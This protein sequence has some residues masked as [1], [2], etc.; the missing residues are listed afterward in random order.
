[1][2]FWDDV[3]RFAGNLTGGFLGESDEERKK[4]AREAAAAKAA[5]KGTLDVKSAVDN[6]GTLSVGSDNTSNDELKMGKVKPQEVTVE[7]PRLQ[8]DEYTRWNVEQFD[9]MD[10]DKQRKTIETAEADL[11]RYKSGNTIEDAHMQYK[12]GKNLDALKTYGKKKDGN[13]LTFGGDIL[14]G[15]GE[16]LRVTGEGLGEG[17]AAATGEN[18]K[19]AEAQNSYADLLTDTAIKQKKAGKISQEQY[20]NDIAMADQERFLA[21]RMIDRDIEAADPIKMA[22]HVASAIATPISYAAGVGSAGQAGMAG[23]GILSSKAAGTVLPSILRSNATQLVARAFPSMGPKMLSTTGAILE[24]ILFNAPQAAT[25]VAEAKGGDATLADYAGAQLQSAVSS[26]ALP[27]FASVAGTIISKGA[28]GITNQT[29]SRAVQAVIRQ[30]ETKLGRK[31]DDAELNVIKG[32]TE[33]IVAQARKRFQQG[34]IEAGMFDPTGKLGKP[35]PLEQEAIRFNSPREFAKSLYDRVQNF[36]KTMKLTNAQKDELHQFV[37]FKMQDRANKPPQWVSDAFDNAQ[38]KN[39]ARIQAQV[40]APQVTKTVAKFKNADEVANAFKKETGSDIRRAEVELGGWEMRRNQGQSEPIPYTPEQIK[41]IDKYNAIKNP[42]SQYLFHTTPTSNLDSIRKNGLTTGNKPRFEGVSNPKEISLSANELAAEYYGSGND[43][44]IRVSKKYGKTIPDLKG[45]YLAGG[46]GVYK[47]SQ[48]IPASALEVKI[49]GKWQ[50][51]ESTPQVTKTDITTTKPITTDGVV[52]NPR[53]TGLSPESQKLVDEAD[54]AFKQN[55]L[56]NAKVLQGQVDELNKQLMDLKTVGSQEILDAKLNRQPI[57]ESSADQA[58]AIIRTILEKKREIARLSG[59]DFNSQNIKQLSP[60]E[61]QILKQGIQSGE[62]KPLDVPVPQKIIDLPDKKA[63]TIADMPKIEETRQAISTRIDEIAAKYSPE[64]MDE[65]N[66]EMQAFA[67]SGTKMS[68]EAKAF[69]KELNQEIYQPLYSKSDRAARGNMGNTAKKGMYAPQYDAT[70]YQATGER[71][72]LGDSFI[73]KMNSTF[74]SAA[75][76]KKLVDPNNLLDPIS[77]AKSYTDQVLFDN[78]GHLK[79]AEKLEKQG[80]ANATTYLAEQDR[81]ASDMAKSVDNDLGTSLPKT[82]GVPQ[83]TIKVKPVK[84]DATEFLRRAQSNFDNNGKVTDLRESAAVLPSA[85][86]VRTTRE[87]W[88]RVFSGFHDKEGKALSDYVASG[89]ER[90]DSSG[91]I[92]GQVFKEV[93][94]DVDITK[95]DKKEFVN[96]I[97]GT[98]DEVYKRELDGIIDRE[99]FDDM[100]RVAAYSAYKFDSSLPLASLERNLAGEQMLH[101]GERVRFKDA[102][103]ANRF[104]G[105]FSYMLKDGRRAKSIGDSIT[106]A[107]TTMYHT[108]ALGLNPRSAIQQIT[109]MSRV[110]GVGGGKNTI[111]GIYNA[112]KTMKPG[113]IKKFL[114]SYGIHDSYIQ[115][116]IHSTDDMAKSRFSGKTGTGLVKEG[117]DWVAEGTMKGFN[118]FE[119]A[120]D[121]VMLKTLELKHAK[122]SDPYLRARTIT[123]EFNRIAIKGG[124]YGAI[125]ITNRSNLARLGLQFGQYTMKDWGIM[126]EKFR[127]WRGDMGGAEGKA[128]AGYIAKTLGVKGA[129]SIPMYLMFQSSLAYT[130]GLNDYKGGPALSAIWSMGEEWMNE[131]NRSEKARETGQGNPDFQL[132]NVT[133]AVGKKQ[134][135]LT[136][137]GG[138]YLFNKL[139]LQDAS[140]WGRSLSFLRHDTAIGDI[141]RGYNK[142]TKG[143]NEDG[144]GNARF[145]VSNDPFEILKMGMGGAYNTKES[146]T[147]FQGTDGN[148]F[149]LNGYLNFNFYGM[150]NTQERAQRPVNDKY[151]KQIDAVVANKELTGPQQRTEIAKIINLS[152]DSNKER[153]SYFKPK[154]GDDA[155][156]VKQKLALKAAWDDMN[157]TVWNKETQKNESDVISPE[158]WKIVSADK[159]GKMFEFLRDKANRANKDFGTPVD[160]LYKMTDKGHINQIL[161]TKAMYTGDDKEQKQMLRQQDWYKKYEA[162][163]KT[164]YAQ[165]DKLAF[166]PDSDFG[167]TKRAQSYYDLSQQNPY[168]INPPSAERAEYERI[169]ATGDDAARKAYYKANATVLSAEYGKLDEAAFEWTNAMRKLEGVPPISSADWQNESYG[170]DAKSGG[171]G[172]YGGGGGRDLTVG[173]HGASKSTGIS[174]KGGAKGKLVNVANAVK[175]SKRA[176]GKSPIRIKV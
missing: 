139:G 77:S 82:P 166:D 71:V 153:D 4:K 23:L 157:K 116:M 172:Y 20:A 96:S 78:Y 141:N 30:T 16:G 164:Y 149:N 89:M 114:E 159:D 162:D 113:E 25:S 121:V 111:T 134:V 169:K 94:G 167:Y 173:Q 46:A 9:K 27:A 88:K 1:M 147:Y 142:A 42:S 148:Y 103:T 29:A 86:S 55:D 84:V 50:P 81:L 161:Q 112:V 91:A 2:S 90:R 26:A 40:D 110:A 6:S 58:H 73:D 83:R 101:F 106:N 17:L 158:K 14:R 21:S 18:L 122:I 31:L 56:S 72:A 69:F 62:M 36:D 175:K 7:D 174:F 144:T 156:T 138:N 104:A 87:I 118:A 151:Q 22:G 60:Q 32:Q 49:N 160:P 115:Q 48:N 140:E 119:T 41:L 67:N 108:G 34:S 68:K 133:N 79:K 97:M 171:G 51:L 64:Q 154:P 13:I 126:G 168:S 52:E 145:A 37:Q 99:T 80:F 107:L 124:H 123:D 54:A 19:A 39:T 43:T 3:S 130:M 165:M 74:G 117:Y 152:R 53:P 12:I 35:S 8:L 131:V 85:S 125:D 95:L 137:P 132:T 61:K 28:K 45:D 129:L 102:N 5:S 65:W 63:A 57:P 66:R 38:N 33:Q 15:M 75:Q 146:E 47:T 44:M 24:N 11:R 105:E 93:K 170:F 109:E 10:V 120:K 92:G 127:T 70:Y 100:V 155:A 135:P 176:S 163:L 143:Y 59:E 128:A 136:V 150:N 76:R 98:Y